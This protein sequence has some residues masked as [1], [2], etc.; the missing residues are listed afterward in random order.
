MIE[1]VYELITKG[2][3]ET[4]GSKARASTSMEITED[5]LE[6]LN[7]SG[8]ISADNVLKFVENESKLNLFGTSIGIDDISFTLTKAR[9]STNI[10]FESIKVGDIVP[11]EWIGSEGSLTIIE[12]EKSGES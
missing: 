11:L 7:D 4:D 6:L 9:M 8:K 10:D 3:I 5:N 2:K 1:W 12:F